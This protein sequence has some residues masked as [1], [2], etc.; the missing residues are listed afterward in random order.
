MCPFYI[1]GTKIS[2]PVV[3]SSAVTNNIITFTVTNTERK[4]YDKCGS[5]KVQLT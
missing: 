3:D 2:P 4:D 1:T 5:G